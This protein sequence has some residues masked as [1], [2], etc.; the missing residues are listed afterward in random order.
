[1][2]FSLPLPFEPPLCRLHHPH[3]H[4]HPHRR[5]HHPLLPIPFHHHCNPWPDPHCFCLH[6][7]QPPQ[8]QHHHLLDPNVNLVLIKLLHQVDF[9]FW[10][11]FFWHSINEVNHCSLL[12]AGVLCSC[13]VGEN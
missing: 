11:V 10:H 2:N 13:A 9:L 12:L 6:P 8:Q 3:H 1:M 4:H 5:H 7:H